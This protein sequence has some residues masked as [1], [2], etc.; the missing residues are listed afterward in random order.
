MKYA[1]VNGE[2][3][4][5]QPKLSG[6]CELH[7]CSVIAKCGRVKIWHWAHI[8]KQNCDPSK[9]SETPW[10]RAWKNHF[11]K[12][13]QEVVHVA[14]N[15]DRHRADV[16]TDQGYALEF[17]NSPIKLEEC[18]SRE[19]FYKAMIWIVNGTERPNDK[20]KFINA[21]KCSVPIKGKVEIWKLN[22][23]FE[24]CPLLRDW[25][26]SSAPVFFDFGE[27]FLL[28]ILPKDP[29]EEKRYMVGIDRS[30][31]IASFYPTQEKSF[32]RLIIDWAFSIVNSQPQKKTVAPSQ[33]LQ[34]QKVNYAFGRYSR[35]RP[36]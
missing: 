22:D 17:Q 10:H 35:R 23:G 36:L 9:E 19:D 18:Q 24:K 33:N 15:G 20:A 28:G 4:E 30:A 31:L 29:S 32:R 3:Q 21:W 2:R 5:A 11:P 27:D 6:K 16:K 34:P 8:G 12:E 13:W 7:G 26:D 1:L 14:E 25:A